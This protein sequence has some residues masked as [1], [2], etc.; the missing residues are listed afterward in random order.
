ML[1]IAMVTFREGLEALLIIAISIVYFSS[2]GAT[3][4]VK[5][6]AVGAILAVISC[7]GLG[8]LF[9]HI[10]GLAPIWEACLATFAAVL[11]VSCTWHMLK[12]GPKMGL[13]IRERLARVSE[14]KAFG[15]VLIT[16]F[17]MLGREGLEAAAMLASLATQEETQ[18]LVPAAAAGLVLAVVVAGLW[19]KLGRAVNLSSV[20]KASA[21]FMSIF[22]I[23]LV[24]YAFHEFS[25][26]NAIPMLDNNY[27]HLAT[28]DYSPEGVYGAWLSYMM[29]ASPFLYAIYAKLTK[30]KQ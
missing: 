24:I 3:N 23:Q 4:L 19:L 5:A 16:S 8:M 27:W 22:S 21:I 2:L 15:A 7:I 18:S 28:E 26:A 10:G 17:L 14:G 20:F 30:N 12:H 9:A 13:I 1:A 11:V 29:A 6:V 25:E